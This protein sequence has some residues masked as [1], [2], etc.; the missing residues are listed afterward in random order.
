MRL[1]RPGADHRD[2]CD[3][4]RRVQIR[5]FVRLAAWAS[6]ASLLLG[7]ARGARGRA[8]PGLRA[9]R[10]GREPAGRRDARGRRGAAERRQR[11]RRRGRDGL[12]ARRHRP[13]LTRASA[14]AASCCAARRRAQLSR[15]TRAR[16]RRPP[17]RATCIMRAG[18]AA[19]DAS[20]IGALAVATPGLVAGLALAHER[21]GTRPLADV[22]APGDPPRGARASRRPAPRGAARVLAEAGARGALPETARIQLPPG[23]APLEPGLRLVQPDLAAHAAAIAREGPA[24]RSTR[25]RSRRRSPTRCSAQGGI[26]T[27]R[28]PRA[29]RA[30]SCASRCAA[31]TA[32]SRCSRSRRRR[33]AAS[34]SRDAERPRGLRRSRALGAGSS[35]SVHRIAEAMKLAFADRARA[36]RRPRLRRRARRRAHRRSRYAERA[37]RAHRPAALAARAVDAG[38]A[39]ESRSRSSGPASRRATTRGTT[40]FSVDRR[41]GQRGRAHADDQ[42]ALRLGHHGARHR[43]HPEQRDGRLRGR[44]RHGRTPSASSTRAARTRSRPASARSR[45]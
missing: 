4:L 21:Y 22:L 35:A 31:A 5:C 37:A 1:G 34:R 28:G 41:G 16:R 19:S 27:A 9:R 40:H 38:A 20:R 30:R 32:G 26:L 11:D 13:A 7:L 36:P 6:F 14:A 24:R 33:R 44:A 18:R 12:R 23:G 45:A 3:S 42:P 10:H 15:S 25:R 43:H 29:L 8:G 39:R 2:A 17:R